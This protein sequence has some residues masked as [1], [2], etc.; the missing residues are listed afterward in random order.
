MEPISYPPSGHLCKNIQHNIHT[1]LVVV[2]L[3]GHRFLWALFLIQGSCLSSVNLWPKPESARTW[4][5]P[6]R[7]HITWHNNKKNLYKNGYMSNQIPE[8]HKPLTNLTYYTNT[9]WKLWLRNCHLNRTNMVI[10]F[11]PERTLFAGLSTLMY[12]CKTIS[13]STVYFSIFPLR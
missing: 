7:E 3:Q 6:A 11:P 13:Q 4:S 2:C 1:P 8:G 9:D 10:F 12:I 5:P